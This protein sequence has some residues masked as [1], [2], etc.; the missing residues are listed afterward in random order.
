MLNVQEE[1]LISYF[2]FTHKEKHTSCRS[3][4][5]PADRQLR[6]VSFLRDCQIQTQVLGSLSGFD[7]V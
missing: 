5:R 7:S 1:Q 6:S 4:W 3:G 2:I